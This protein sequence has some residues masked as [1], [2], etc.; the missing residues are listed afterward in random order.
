MESILFLQN[1]LLSFSMGFLK[2][3]V[4]ML[5]NFICNYKWRIGMNGA[6]SF[7]QPLL[8]KLFICF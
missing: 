2:A 1:D 8:Q 7:F 3:A 4:M 5:Q 6:V